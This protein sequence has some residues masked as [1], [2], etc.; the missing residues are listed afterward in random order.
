MLDALIRD[1]RHGARVLRKSPGFTL[2]SILILGLGIGANAAIF[3]VVNAVVLRPLP[4]ADSSRIVRIWHV[5]P[6]EQFSGMS[7]FS[8]SPANYLAWRAP[9]TP[10]DYMAV[11]TQRP[12]NLTGQGQP[13]SLQAAL[14]SGDFF[15]VLG[16][17]PLL[18]RLLDRGDDAPDRPHVVVLGEALW[19]TRFG[20]DPNIVGQSITLDG[21]PH[22][23]VGV[24]PQR[25]RFPEHSDVWLP[26]V[27]DAKERAVRGNH[28]YLVIA[29]LKPGVDLQRA[30]SEL[31]TISKRLEQQ[32]P[33]D[34]KG[35]GAVVIPLHQDLVGDVRWPLLVL[36]G[37]VGCVLLIACANLANLFLARVLGR[38][39]EIAIRAAVGASRGRIVQQL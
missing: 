32:Y 36:L 30:Q 20:A 3:S 10:F 21:Q 6:R 24:V 9:S 15:N 8:V 16:A 12:R 34:D 33:V 38:R 17:R 2:L 5:P 29:R 14:V 26:L 37:A 11:Y 13:D 31:T 7:T 23:I 28:N 25:V 27:W 39:K 18:G 19:K 4:F 1:A 35:W 22:A